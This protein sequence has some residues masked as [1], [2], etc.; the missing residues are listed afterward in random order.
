LV[1][2]SNVIDYHDVADIIK[3]NPTMMALLEQEFKK[4]RM[5]E[6]GQEEINLTNI[7]KEL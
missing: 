1:E 5:I 7:F 6:P 3:D 2:G 4:R